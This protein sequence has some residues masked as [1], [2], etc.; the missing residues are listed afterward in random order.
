MSRSEPNCDASVVLVHGAWHGGWCWD[1]VREQLTVRGVPTYAVDLPMTALEDDVECVQAVLG[2]IDAPVVI[3]AHRYGGAVA[4]A[5]AANNVN[6][7][8]RFYLCA[9]VPAEGEAVLSQVTSA[10]GCLRIPGW[11]SIREVR[12]AGSIRTIPRRQP[13]E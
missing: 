3:C 13:R 2:G 7:L 1:A 5:A 9:V 10:C 6:V 8:H 4:T 12:Q 11:E